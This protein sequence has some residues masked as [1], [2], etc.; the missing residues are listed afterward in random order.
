MSADMAQFTA[1]SDYYDRNWS[2]CSSPIMPWTLRAAS[3]RRRHQDAGACRRHRRPDHSLPNRCRAKPRLRRPIQWR[4]ARSCPHGACGRQNVTSRL[5]MRWSCL[6]PT[7][8]STRLL[9]FGV[10]FFPTKRL[11]RRSDA[12][13][14]AGGRYVFNVW[15]AWSAMFSRAY[16][17][18]LRPFLGA[19][20]R[21]S[22]R[23]NR[24]LRLDPIRE[25]MEEAGFVDFNANIVK[26]EKPVPMSR[27][28]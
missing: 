26:I 27:D 20:R 6:S 4:H 8:A 7:A 22:S 23:S 3:P 25:T 24:L 2:P 19:G 11:L 21:A 1:V 10:M 18:R 15:T 28:L 16:R 17:A 14:R 9:Q 12:R 13:A 5:P